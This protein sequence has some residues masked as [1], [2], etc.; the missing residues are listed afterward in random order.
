MIHDIFLVLLSGCPRQVVG[1]GALPHPV[2][3]TGTLSSFGTDGIDALIVVVDKET[4]TVPISGLCLLESHD[5]QSCLL[6]VERVG[7]NSPG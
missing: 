2:D 5:D 3:G 4:V 1:N 7:V 6:F